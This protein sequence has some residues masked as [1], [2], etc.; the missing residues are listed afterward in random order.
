MLR[1]TRCVRQHSSYWPVQTIYDT[2]VLEMAAKEVLKNASV[3]DLQAVL[4][5]VPTAAL[6]ACS[7]ENSQRI[8][9]R[10]R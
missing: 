10:V 3:T 9:V 5:C 6:R 1:Q 4:S 2:Q 8:T 7:V